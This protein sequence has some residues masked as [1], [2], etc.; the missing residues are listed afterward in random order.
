MSEADNPCDNAFMGRTQQ[1]R[2]LRR[3]FKKSRNF[4]MHNQSAIHYTKEM[5]SIY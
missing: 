2:N 4:K 3:T 5:V 1:S